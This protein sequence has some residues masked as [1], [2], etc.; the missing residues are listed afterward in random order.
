MLEW[1]HNVLSGLLLT[2]LSTLTLSCG[3]KCAKERI[4]MQITRS[5]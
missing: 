1:V 3:D 4:L 2:A 5:T